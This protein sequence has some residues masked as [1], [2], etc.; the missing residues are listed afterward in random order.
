MSITSL[1][2]KYESLAAFHASMATLE[3]GTENASAA[4]NYAEKA[5]LCDEIVSSLKE[6]LQTTIKGV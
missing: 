6:L 3:A 2:G 1:I 5:Q 4:T